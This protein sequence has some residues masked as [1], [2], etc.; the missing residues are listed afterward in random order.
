MPHSPAP[1]K[2]EADVL[3]GQIA[4]ICVRASEG[5]LE[6]RITGITV[7]GD[8]ARLCGAINHLLDVADSYVRE[9]AAAMDQCAK[10]RYHRPILL[11][12]IPGSYRDSAL[13]I[14]KAALKMKS[15]ADKITQFEEER[16]RVAARVTA[17]TDA[18]S[19]SSKTVNL[20]AGD[21]WQNA[22]KT[23]R[24][25]AEVSASASE[26]SA[27]VGGVAAA[28]EE[29]NSTTTEIARQTNQSVGLTA[30]A[31]TEVG[32][33]SQSIH[34]LGEAG[35]K[36]ASVV[37]L[38]NKIAH[39]TNLLALNATIEAAR[40]GEHGRG[41]AVVANEVKILSQDTSKATDTIAAQVDTMRLVT[42]KVM[43]AITG[44]ESSIK[45]MNDN[46]TTISAAVGEQVTA[47]AEISKRVSE[48]S[49]NVEQI[50]RTIASVT[51]AAS[52]TELASGQLKEAASDLTTQAD[53]LRAAV[54]GL[55]PKAA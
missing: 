34:E 45:Q 31:V 11:R 44:I 16:V 18:V 19:G 1:A 32:Q 27:N 52:E 51:Q 39:Q 3:I 20:T 21:L 33:A 42:G 30:S 12:G 46:A 13:T 40:A 37:E 29:L 36:I 24:L 47:T 48:A 17:T 9:S 22:D 43:Q 5:D 55:A 26:T 53:E 14:N 41:F 2:T 49:Q 7:Q 50:S 35:T 23:K 4:D 54:S 25:S 15:D 38:I 8:L 6:A 28:C 10:G